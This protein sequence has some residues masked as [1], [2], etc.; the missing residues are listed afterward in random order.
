[1]KF[2]LFKKY[3]LLVET[4]Q[5]EKCSKAPKTWGFLLSGFIGEMLRRFSK[6]VVLF[7]KFFLNLPYY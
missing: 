6:L 7:Q 2:R 4:D 5:S 1:M 3:F